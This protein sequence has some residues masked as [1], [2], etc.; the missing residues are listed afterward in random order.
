ML[1]S[2]KNLLALTDEYC[3]IT[4]RSRTTVSL[5]VFSAGMR[6]QQ[7]AD[8]SQIT[9][10]LYN[11]AMQWLSDN[12]P[13]E[14]AWLESIERPSPSPRTPE[15]VPSVTRRRGRGANDGGTE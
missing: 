11:R 15:S 4:G 2:L 8:G 13:V 14:K 1:P 5:E 12:W 7:I 10:E 6:L 3:R 9:V